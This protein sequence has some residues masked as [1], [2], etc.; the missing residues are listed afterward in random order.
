VDEHVCEKD[1]RNGNYRKPMRHKKMH[2]E[3]ANL[4]EAEMVLLFKSMLVILFISKLKLHTYGQLFNLHVVLG[5]S[6]HVLTMT[7]RYG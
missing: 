7:P 5:K 3:N 4:Y 6:V 2:H 1:K